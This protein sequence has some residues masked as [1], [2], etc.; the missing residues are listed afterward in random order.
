VLGRRAWQGAAFC[1][2]GRLAAWC[3]LA[4]SNSGLDRGCFR[5]GGTTLDAHR[6]VRVDGCLADQGGPTVS[7]RS[8]NS[9]IVAASPLT[10]NGESRENAGAAR[11]M[12]PA[13]SLSR[14]RAE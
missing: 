1:E 6:G 9:A 2:G 13:P 7:S 4:R 14:L 3:R 10:L 11:D 5:N 12:P 8:T